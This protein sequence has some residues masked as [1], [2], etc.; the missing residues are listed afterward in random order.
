M[1]RWNKKEIS[2]WIFNIFSLTT[3]WNKLKVLQDGFYTYLQ[4]MDSFTR[5]LQKEYLRQE[6]SFLVWIE[7]RHAPLNP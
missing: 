7:E 1:P 5:I 3:Q 6:K 4:S 2:K